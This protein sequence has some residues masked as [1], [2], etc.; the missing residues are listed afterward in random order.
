[1]TN[2][3][4]LE[5]AAIELFIEHKL[6]YWKLAIVEKCSTATAVATCNYQDR[7]IYVNRLYTETHDLDRL[8]Q[9]LYHEVAHVIAGADADHG[10]TW[11]RIARA[12]GCRDPQANCTTSDEYRIQVYKYQVA[13]QHDD[14]TIE[15][16]PN[17]LGIRRSKLTGRYVDGRPETKGKLI[18]VPFEI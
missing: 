15:K 4:H 6:H 1:M 8:M 18:W 10:P 11:K 9:T 12:L 16:I 17:C 2:A 5:A 14:G 3:Q 7:T 13:V